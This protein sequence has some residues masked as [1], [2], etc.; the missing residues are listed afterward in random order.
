MIIKR[1]L[2]FNELENYMSDIVQG[3]RETNFKIKNIVEC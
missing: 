2:H 3:G 1:L